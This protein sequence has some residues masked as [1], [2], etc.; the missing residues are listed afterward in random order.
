MRWAPSFLS[1]TVVLFVTPK[2]LF[3]EIDSLTDVP[4]LRVCRGELQE[5]DRPPRPPVRGLLGAVP[6]QGREL[7]VAPKSDAHR[8]PGRCGRLGVGVQRSTAGAQEPPGHAENPPSGPFHNRGN[9]LGPAPSVKDTPS[10]LPH[11][12]R[13]LPCLLPP[14]TEGP[15]PGPAPPRP[16]RSNSLCRV[17]RTEDLCLS[18]PPR[19]NGPPP[20]PARRN[21]L[22]P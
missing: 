13:T 7:V 4:L 18:P 6:R 3:R 20:D 5:R 17:P 12:P 22:R 19:A 14:H 1:S 15:P 9:A 10:V 2:P 11:A 8:G 21:W 16:P